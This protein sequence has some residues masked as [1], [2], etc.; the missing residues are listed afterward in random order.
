MEYADCIKIKKELSKRD[1]GSYVDS[2]GSIQKAVEYV[3]EHYTESLTREE[4]CK[5]AMMS[6]TAFTNLFK[7]VTGES[8]VEYIHILRVSLAK[9]LL[10]EN[11]MNITEVGERCGFDSTT[12]FGRVFKKKTGMT[13]KQ[14]KA[15]NDKK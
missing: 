2:Y 15:A 10:C 12:Y 8:L 11:K 7:Q 14:Y 4:V 5:V 9:Q 13:P 1:S 3:N 6:K